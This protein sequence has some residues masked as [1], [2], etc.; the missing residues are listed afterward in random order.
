MKTIW[1]GLWLSCID[2]KRAI[3]A[4]MCAFLLMVLPGFAAE[5]NFET[6]LEDG[7]YATIITNKGKIT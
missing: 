2:I 7:L 6:G 3:L 5:G 4:V 1:R